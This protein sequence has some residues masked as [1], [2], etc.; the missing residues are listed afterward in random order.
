M[1]QQATSGQ[2]SPTVTS[3]TV[4]GRDVSTPSEL[5]SS[6]PARLDP[7][8]TS[9]P[10]ITFKT[11]M[12]YTPSSV[13]SCSEPYDFPAQKTI[14]ESVSVF[15]AP[16]IQKFVAPGVIEDVPL[17]Y[18]PV[19][20]RPVTILPLGQGVDV[21]ETSGF[22]PIQQQLRPLGLPTSRIQT[23]ATQDVPSTKV[24][25]AWL[26]A[27]DNGDT[28]K[29]SFCWCCFLK[30]KTIFHSTRGVRGV[31]VLSSQTKTSRYVI[32]IL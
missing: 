24:S 10:V 7:L 22:I 14:M 1:D 18:T 29:V 28:P 4:A 13:A 25:Q 8:T 20:T 31:I 2:S 27:A 3:V 9:T 6:I 19:I 30:T 23:P 26:P 32:V 16:K 12:S 15:E 11:P 21:E 5:K 17:V